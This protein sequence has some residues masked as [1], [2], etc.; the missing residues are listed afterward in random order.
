MLQYCPVLQVYGAVPSNEGNDNGMRFQYQNTN[1]VLTF[2]LCPLQMP[3]SHRYICAA[4][5]HTKLRVMTRPILRHMGL[6][7][8]GEQW[9]IHWRGRI[10]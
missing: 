10:C 5:C 1:T 8:S 3:P 6:G 9:L 4:L 7:Q 2:T